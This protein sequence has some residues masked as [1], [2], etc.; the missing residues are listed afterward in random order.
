M[1]PE[2]ARKGVFVS[3]TPFHGTNHKILEGLIK[4]SKLEYCVII[5]AAHIS[6]HHLLTWGG[7]RRDGQELEAFNKLEQ[8]VLAWMGNMVKKKLR[9]KTCW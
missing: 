2:Q 8:D 9:F 3:S 1:V 6:V 5:T 7:G 4:K